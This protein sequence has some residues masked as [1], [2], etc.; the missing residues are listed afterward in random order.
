MER[1]GLS[2]EPAVVRLGSLRSSDRS[3][4]SAGLL[5]HE[6]HSFQPSKRH[7]SVRED[8]YRSITVIK[9]TILLRRRS[10]MTHDEF[11][12]YHRDQH[13]PLF[14]ALAEVKQYVRR[15][16]QCHAIGDPLPG[17]PDNHIDGSTELWFEDV[18]GIAG[19]FESANYMTTIRPDEE[20]FL[21]LHGCE[22]LLGEESE[23][24]AIEQA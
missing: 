6:V 24:I 16:V 17:L 20:K 21:D 9:M 8:R 2:F 19:V 22:F 1:V 3:G 7:I 10:D 11:V 14:C 4:G 13:A 23:V 18:A 5:L 12:A 15:Y